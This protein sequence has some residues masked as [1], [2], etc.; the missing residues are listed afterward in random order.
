MRNGI[1]R[2]LGNVQSQVFKCLGSMGMLE[3]SGWS[4]ERLC[5]GGAKPNKDGF[6]LRLLKR[7]RF[8]VQSNEW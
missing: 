5:E 2:H 6:E 4:L 7:A 3:N 1:H 8:E